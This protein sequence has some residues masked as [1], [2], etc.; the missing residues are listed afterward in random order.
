MVRTTGNVEVAPNATWPNETLAGFAPR[1]V[2]VAPVPESLNCSDLFEALLVN[3]IPCCVYPTAVGEKFT[4]RETLFPGDKV[5]GKVSPG[6]LKP[7]A[8]AVIAEI[9]TLVDP[10][11]VTMATSVSGC[12]ITTL[13]KFKT[14]GVHVSC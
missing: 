8:L 2:L 3:V 7:V 4:F 11:F 13:P 9:V 6:A 5:N 1:L 12:P 10:L 14:E